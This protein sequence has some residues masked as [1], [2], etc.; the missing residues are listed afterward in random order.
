[1]TTHKPTARMI[2]AYEAGKASQNQDLTALI[3]SGDF[4]EA[5]TEGTLGMFF[6]AGRSG[7]EMPRWA[8]GWRYGV[9]P[10]CGQSYNHRDDRYE[11]GI[12]MMHVDGCV[13]ESDGSYEMFNGSQ[14]RVA[15]EGWLI[16]HKRGAD[17][18]PL[19]WTR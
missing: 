12:S 1:M 17:G 18:E 11:A 19:L 9:A 6:E 8:T 3:W 7:A 16:T 13:W 14:D 15:V 10:E 5:Y 2:Q 4:D